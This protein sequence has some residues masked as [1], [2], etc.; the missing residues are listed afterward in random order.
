MYIW[1]TINRNH[2]SPQTGI[3]NSF[4]D[5]TN[6]F[7][8]LFTHAEGSTATLKKRCDFAICTAAGK[9]FSGWG[10]L[11]NAEYGYL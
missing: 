11:S 3:S 10:G 7:K 2:N 4:V 8:T 5:A 9:S 1:L 6:N